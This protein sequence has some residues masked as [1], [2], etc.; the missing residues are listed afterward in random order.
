MTWIYL[1]PHLDDGVLSCGGLV[2]DQA[3]AGEQVWILT[4]CAGDPPPGDLPPFARTQ[5]AMWGLGQAAVAARREEDR[6]ACAIL[7]AVPVH[8]GIP[9]CIYRR[10]PGDGQPLYPSEEAIFGPL[11]PQELGLIDE[12]ARQL[13][14][15][16]PPGARLVC[17]LGVGGHVDHRLTRAAA[18]RLGRDL[19]YYAEVPYVLRSAV[20]AQARSPLTRAEGWQAT[21]FPLLEAALEAWQKA[22]A[23]YRSQVPVLWGNTPA[24]CSELEAYRRAVGGIRLW[25]RGL[26]SVGQ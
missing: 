13:A 3:R 26:P 21:R 22:A 17:P 6:Q 1:S 19:W 20:W 24:M 18:E 12:L 2:Y 15:Q 14:D 8:L 16:M 9:D 4:A 7:G 23:A 11:H 10:S 5:H 25:R